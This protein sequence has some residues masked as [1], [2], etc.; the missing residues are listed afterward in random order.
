MALEVED[1]SGKTNS[2]SYLSVAEAD[3]YFAARGNPTAWSGAAT[4]AKEQYLREATEYVDAVYGRRWK[5]S[6]VKRDQ[7]LDWPRFGVDNDDG[8]ILDSDKI[9]ESLKRATAEAALRR[10]TDELIPD[11]DEPGTIQSESVSVGPISQSITYQG[12]RE[13]VKKFRK[14]DLLLAELI[15]RGA[16]VLDAVRG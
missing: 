13:Q 10:A 11:I 16:G 12:G 2:E 3:A 15:G 8:W 7:A 4:S 1:G 9:P 14:I 6:L 5:G